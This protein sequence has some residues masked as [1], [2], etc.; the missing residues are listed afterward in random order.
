MST[1]P[2]P[3]PYVAM[4]VSLP[5]QGSSRRMRP[6]VIVSRPVSMSPIF[7]SIGLPFITLT[8]PSLRSMMKSALWMYALRK[9]SFM[10]SPL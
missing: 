2:R 8:A 7:Q 3:S 4:N 10:Y 9:Y 5:S 6:P 1:L